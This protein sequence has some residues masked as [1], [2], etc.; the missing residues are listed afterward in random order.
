MPDATKPYRRQR[1]AQFNAEPGS[2]E[3][4]EVHHGPVWNAGTE[5]GLRG[6]CLA[7]WPL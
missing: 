6:N 3:A 2:R 1:L 4:L 5:P 7:S